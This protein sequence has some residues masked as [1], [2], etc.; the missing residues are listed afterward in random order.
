MSVDARWR[1]LQIADSAFPTGGF[2]HSGGL[3][4][5]VS[6]GVVDSVESFDAFVRT[7]LWTCGHGS[8]PFVAAAHRHPEDVE[9]L[10]AAVDAQ[11][12]N[13]V[14]NR[15][16]RT[17]GRA[18]LATAARV[19]EAPA[20]VALAERAAQRRITAHYPPV[21]G[22]SLAALEISLSDALATHLL[23]ALRGVASAAVRLG[24]VGPNE[25]Q[26][27]QGRHAETLDAV[28]A[29]CRTLTPDDAACVAPIFDALGAT[30]DRLYA[31]LFQS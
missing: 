22:A 15:A 3:E 13:H 7:H 25:A 28:L 1:V 26:R 27:I 6:A 10:D 30:H 9:S 5:A 23:L 31:R 11:L 20:V 18:F 8:L 24:I 2:A 17:Q 14:A 16:S 19:F 12:V 29:E 4:P 21:F